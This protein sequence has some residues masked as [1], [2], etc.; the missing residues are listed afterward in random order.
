MSRAGRC[1][2]LG[3][4]LLAACSPAPQVDSAVLE[5]EFQPGVDLDQA[6]ARLDQHHFTYTLRSPGECAALA[7]EGRVRS[8]LEPRG[9]PCVFGKLPG[10]QNWHGGHSDVIVQLVFGSDCKLSD[11]HF[12]TLELMF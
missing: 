6:L 1:L 5:A 3:A 9:G 4:L 7:S 10:P 2:A 11:G 8:Q 12:E